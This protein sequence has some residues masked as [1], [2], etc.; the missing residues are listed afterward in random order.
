M[1]WSLVAVLALVGGF[2]LWRHQKNTE[3]AKAATE[4]LAK[5]NRLYQHIKAGMREYN[6]R[7]DQENFFGVKSG[8][9]LFETAHLSAYRVSHFAELRVG[10]HFKDTDE[11]GLYGFFAGEPGEYFD[12][13]YR[14]DQT[15][16]KEGRLL[17]DD[18]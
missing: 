15:F 4:R 7:K 17:H 14:T 6:W 10:F 11:Y 3:R 12:S 1:D 16:Q 5:D 8:E 9:P 13:Y 18:D 2:F